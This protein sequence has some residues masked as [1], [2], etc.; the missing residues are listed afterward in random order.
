MCGL[1]ALPGLLFFFVAMVFEN[2]IEPT[3][4]FNIDTNYLN[5]I[6]NYLYI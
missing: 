3:C 6:T 2:A 1:A 4:N 5:I